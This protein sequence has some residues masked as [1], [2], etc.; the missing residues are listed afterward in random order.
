MSEC[1]NHDY[2]QGRDCQRRKAEQPFDWNNEKQSALNDWFLSLPEKRQKALIQDKW[3][4]AGAAF[5]AGFFDGMSR[6]AVFAG[7]LDAA[8][9]IKESK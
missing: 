2:N 6:A 7:A 8:H 9:G 4:L 3:T 5:E 1:G